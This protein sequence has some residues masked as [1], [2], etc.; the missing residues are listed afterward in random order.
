M[1]LNFQRALAAVVF[2]S[3]VTDSEVEWG[4]ASGAEIKTLPGKS[5]NEGFRRAFWRKPCGPDLKRFAAR[6]SYAAAAP[7]IHQQIA[8]PPRSFAA[9]QSYT[10]KPDFVTAARRD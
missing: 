4:L 10:Q 1:P 7:R 8:K 5:L 9:R 2:D 6:I 3:K